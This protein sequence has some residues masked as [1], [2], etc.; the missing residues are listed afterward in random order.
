MLGMPLGSGE[1][2][3]T[4]Q[5]LERLLMASSIDLHIFSDAFRWR[6]IAGRDFSADLAPDCEPLRTVLGY[7]CAAVPSILTGCTP[8][9]VCGLSSPKEMPRGMGSQ[10]VGHSLIDTGRLEAYPTANEDGRIIWV[11]K[12]QQQ[13]FFRSRPVGQ[14]DLPSVGL[15]TYH[16]R[17]QREWRKKGEGSGQADSK[18]QLRV[19]GRPR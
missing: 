18:L 4:I 15:T 11:I 14:T 17:V 2:A 19:A 8:A 10:P 3:N 7:P 6:M 16:P 1:S 12:N 9:E 13:S 5:I